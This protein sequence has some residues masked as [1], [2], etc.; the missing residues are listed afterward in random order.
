[1]HPTEP[2][3][4][5]QSTATR[6]GYFYDAR[7]STPQSQRASSF[8]KTLTRQTISKTDQNSNVYHRLMERPP[9]ILLPTIKL[10]FQ[11]CRNTE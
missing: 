6:T 4:A 7:M 5:Q 9:R 3:E 11:K 2:N 1:M 8:P 10:Q